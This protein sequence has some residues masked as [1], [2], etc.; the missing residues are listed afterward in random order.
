MDVDLSGSVSWGEFQ[1]GMSDLKVSSTLEV[2][3]LDIRD[4]GFLLETL[5]VTGNRDEVDF[6]FLVEAFTR[7]EGP[8]CSL[9]LSAPAC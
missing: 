6:D 2:M 1:A 3:G 8:A 7:M 5:C 4:A 9:D